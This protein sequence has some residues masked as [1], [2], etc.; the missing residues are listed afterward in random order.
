[1]NRWPLS[2][3]QSRTR[4]RNVAVPPRQLCGDGPDKQNTTCSTFWANS[5]HGSPTVTGT[6]LPDTDEHGEQFGGPKP[7]GT[8]LSC[9]C[10]GGGGE[11]KSND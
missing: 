9:F 4:Q 1:M 3:K 5:V 7:P 2:D 10:S 6:L 8:K 11:K